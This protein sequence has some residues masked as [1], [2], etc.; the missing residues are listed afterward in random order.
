MHV[1]KYIEGQL[2]IYTSHLV[3]S[4]IWLNLPKEGPSP[5]FLGLSMDGCHSGSKRKFL[6]NAPV[7][8]VARGLT[9]NPHIA[10]DIVQIYL[11]LKTK[12]ENIVRGPC[13]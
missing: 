11:P 1:A 8:I 9:Y 2:N 13:T 6:Q 3:Y 12:T 7:R 4:Q 10:S 5:I